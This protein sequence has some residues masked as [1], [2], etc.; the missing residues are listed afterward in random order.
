M[1]LTIMRKSKYYKKPQRFLPDKKNSFQR[2]D[3]DCV[4]L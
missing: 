3:K 1:I 4:Q 2:I